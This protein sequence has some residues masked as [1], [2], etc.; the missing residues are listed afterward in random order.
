MI[1]DKL[2]L[3]RAHRNN[4]SRYHRLLETQLTDFERRYIERRLSEERSAIE[5]LVA[6]TCPMDFQ[7]PIGMVKMATTIESTTSHG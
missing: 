5:R 6:S 1:D 2:A 3:V 4:I 7:T